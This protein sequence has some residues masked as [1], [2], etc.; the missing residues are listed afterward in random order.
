MFGYGDTQLI[1]PNNKNNTTLKNLIHK[2]IWL[3]IRVTGRIVQ[4]TKDSLKNTH[5]L[6]TSLFIHKP[7]FLR[8]QFDY[9]GSTKSNTKKYNNRLFY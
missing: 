4:K 5:I 7:N 6:H 3:K 8:F 1:G 9:L 2:N